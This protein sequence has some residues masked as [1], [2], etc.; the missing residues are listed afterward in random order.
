MIA[1]VS[2]VAGTSAK[3]F[4]YPISVHRTATHLIR[5]A[6]FATSDEYLHRVKILL[7]RLPAGVYCV[8]YHLADL[9]WAS[10]DFEVSE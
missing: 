9:C 10:V 1:S 5:I 7:E 8:E 3:I 2:A 6:E 4:L